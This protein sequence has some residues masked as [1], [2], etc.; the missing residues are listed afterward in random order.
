M[1]ASSVKVGKRPEQ[2]RAKP[3][4][5]S[6]SLT[7]S[8]TCR[9]LAYCLWTPKTHS[10][11][12]STN[13]THPPSHTGSMALSSIVSSISTIEFWLICQPIKSKK[14]KKRRHKHKQEHANVNVQICVN[15]YTETQTQTDRHTHT[16]IHTHTQTHRQD[17]YERQTI[18]GCC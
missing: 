3:R 18:H 6:H 12:H 15:D 2:S 8:Q 5:L 13:S 9:A 1:W 14:K 16:H 4:L 17:P 10:A 7:H 11:V